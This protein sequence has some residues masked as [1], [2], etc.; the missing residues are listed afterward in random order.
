V[1]VQYLGQVFVHTF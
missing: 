1:T